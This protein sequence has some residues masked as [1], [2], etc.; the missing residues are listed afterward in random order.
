VK[1]I[2]SN[3]LRGVPILLGLQALQTIAII[4]P[5]AAIQLLTGLCYG[6]WWGMLI[7]VAGCVLGNIIVFIALRQLKSLLAPFF[8]RASKHK[9]FLTPQKLS[10]MKKPEMTVFLLFLIPGIP[11]GIVPYVFA[12]TKV[13]LSKYIVAVVAGSIPSMFLYSFIGDRLSKGN[14]SLSIALAVVVIVVVVAVI[15]FRKKIMVKITAE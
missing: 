10:H 3:G 6:V 13:P 8:T 5:A 14:Y 2:N 12:Q 1:Y 4:I 9:S 7:N 11:N 15:L